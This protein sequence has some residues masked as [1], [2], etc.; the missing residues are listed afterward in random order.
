VRVLRRESAEFAG[1]WE[2]HEVARR[3]ADRKTLLHP[4]VGAVELDCQVLFTEDRTQTLLVF[5][6]EPRTEAHEKL[7]L[8]SVLGADSYSPAPG[9]S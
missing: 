9:G 3:F 7:R 5:T 1:L 8:L 4:E 2:R 6:A